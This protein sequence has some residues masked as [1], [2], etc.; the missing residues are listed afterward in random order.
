MQYV[1]L[2]DWLPSL[3]IT[4]FK[5]HLNCRRGWFIHFWEWYAIVGGCYAFCLSIHQLVDV[6][7]VR[8]LASV[9]SAA[10]SEGVSVSPVLIPEKNVFRPSFRG[11]WVTYDKSYPAHPSLPSALTWGLRTSLVPACAITITGEGW[12]SPPSFFWFLRKAVW[13]RIWVWVGQSPKTLSLLLE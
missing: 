13:N 8:I 11:L 7:V 3:R 2:C 12:A 6:S 4:F 1:I 9:S 10:L 5:A